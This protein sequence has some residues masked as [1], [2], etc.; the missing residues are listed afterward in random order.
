V[1]PLYG[2]VGSALAGFDEVEGA[3]DKVALAGRRRALLLAAAFELLQVALREFGLWVEGIDVRW[4]TLYHQEDAALGLGRMVD[5]SR[6]AASLQ[7]RGE[8]EGEGTDAC[9]ETVECLAAGGR[10]M[11]DE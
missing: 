1:P 2:K 4:P 7:R 9:A 11:S 8:G 5:C 10:D 6:H 3:L